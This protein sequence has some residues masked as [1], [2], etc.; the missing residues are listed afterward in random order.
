M[1]MINTWSH[2]EG[3]LGHGVTNNVFLNKVDR[4]EK[5]VF[6]TRVGETLVN[7]GPRFTLTAILILPLR[8]T[9]PRSHPLLN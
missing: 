5:M 7:G 3:G 1:T 9:S 4:V 8:N 2:L 6:Y